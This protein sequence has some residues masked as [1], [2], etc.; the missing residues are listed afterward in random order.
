MTREL[1]WTKEDL[2]RCEH[3]RHSI[4]PCVMCPG[5]WSTGN[6][7]LTRGIWRTAVEDSGQVV[8]RIGTMLGGHPILV[9]PIRARESVR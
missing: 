9:T 8:V 7:Y 3:G 2:D 4:D 6:L 5:G 1:S